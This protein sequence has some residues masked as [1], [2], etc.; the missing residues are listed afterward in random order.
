[1]KQLGVDSYRF[2]L[3]WPRIQPTGSGP[4]NRAGLAF[5]DRLL[6]ELLANGISPM[7]TLYHW[8]TP[9]ALD[10]AGGWMNRDTAYRL[11]EFAAIAAAA[12]GDRVAR[13]VHHQRARHR[14][15][16]RLH[17]GP[18]FA[19]ARR[20]CSTPCPPCTTSCWATASP[21][22]PCGQRGSRRDRHDQRVLADGPQL[23]QPPGQDQRR[24]DGPGPEPAVRGPRA[25]R[26][27]PGPHPRREVL[28][29]LRPPGRGHGD[30]LPAAGLLRA[31]LLHAHQ[32]GR[33]PGAK[34]RFRRAWRRPWAA[35]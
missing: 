28:Q 2:S 11:G 32:G 12:Y 33:G 25:D 15:H 31:E 6:D 17:A 27:V 4:V 1:M 14:H 10:D 18:A 21:C 30:H 29:L 8:D 7:V 5:Y 22:R 26:Q 19:R 35:T 23:H 13:W 20:S 16:Q 9:L 34:A 3:A 24:P